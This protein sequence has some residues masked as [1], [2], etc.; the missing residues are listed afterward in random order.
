M[1]ALAAIAARAALPVVDYL[2]VATTFIAAG[3]SAALL[4]RFAQRRSG[5]HLLWWAFGVLVYG[6]GTF[7]EAATTLFGWHA[8]LFRA[9]YISGALM[10]GAPLAQGTAY[11]LLARRTANRLTIALLAVLAVASAF[12]LVNP[13]DYALVEPHRLTGHVF[14]W[15]WARGFSP[16]INLYAFVLLV[17]GAA[18]S[19]W[20]FSRKA[21]TR[22]RF[23]G[24][25]L[26]AV[27]A[28]LPGI[29]GTATRFGHT[30]VL[31]VTELIGL[32]LIYIG[33]RFATARRS[34][35][36][37]EGSVELRDAE[38]RVATR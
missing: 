22:H 8:W 11:L 7:T 34:V 9:W 28:L 18:L 26:I 29:G 31:Y 4:R 5:P 20:R 15:S 12:A 10:G 17:G 27:G 14:E 33:Y 36:S 38:L 19:A 3:F 25:V 21:A 32:V 30:E 2:P 13:I 37:G 23:V 6:L 35:G 16:F 1:T 24:N